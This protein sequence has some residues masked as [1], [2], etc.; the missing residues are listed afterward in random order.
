VLSARWPSNSVR[1]SFGLTIESKFATQMEETFM[2]QYYLGMDYEVIR[3]LPIQYRRWMISRTNEEIN[4]QTSKSND[5]GDVT[6][7]RAPHDNHPMQQQFAGRLPGT[8][9][10][11]RR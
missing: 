7:T 10:S 6:L 2:L 1:S 11:R 3:R 8:P 4:K 9:M 5:S